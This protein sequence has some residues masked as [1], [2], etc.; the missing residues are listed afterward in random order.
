[1]TGD[2]PFTLHLSTVDSISLPAFIAA[3]LFRRD[4]H[5]LQINETD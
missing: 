5:T 4:R 3:I 1:M 2:D